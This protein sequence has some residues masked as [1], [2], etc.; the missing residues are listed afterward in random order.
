MQ[1][2]TPLTKPSE[3]S[4]MKG[5][6]PPSSKLY[7]VPAAF[8]QQPFPTSSLAEDDDMTWKELSATFDRFL[9]YSFSIL[10]A[11]LTVVFMLVL[12]IGSENY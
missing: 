5:V 7:K 1:Y 2:V 4:E 8:S 3:D 12:S 9:F 10:L 11:L 6:V